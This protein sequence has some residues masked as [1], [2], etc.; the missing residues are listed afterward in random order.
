VK[1]LVLV[2]VLASLVLAVG[3]PAYAFKCVS[4][5]KQ[6]NDQIA[7]MD[8]NSAKAKKAKALVEEADKL[9]KAGNQADAVKKAE[10]APAALR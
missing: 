2:L 10:E 8:Q 7:K 3:V 1:K 4:L 6:G 5:I 9:H